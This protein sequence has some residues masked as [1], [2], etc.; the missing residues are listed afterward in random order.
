[1][2]WNGKAKYLSL[3]YQNEDENEI[4]L[5][6]EWFGKRTIKEMLQPIVQSVWSGRSALYDSTIRISV[7]IADVYNINQSLVI[8]V[9]CMSKSNMEIDIY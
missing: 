5:W 8:H 9:A 2:A 4:N 6:I 1:M 3:Q 7:P